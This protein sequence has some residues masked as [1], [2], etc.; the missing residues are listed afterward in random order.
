MPRKDAGC[1]LTLKEAAALFTDPVWA[2]TYP[3]L[4]NVKLAAD[5][6]KVPRNTIY[7][8]SSQGL[9]DDCKARAGKRL[10]LFRDR[11]IVTLSE[12]KLHGN[13]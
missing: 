12:G 4:L 1:R 10:V 13:G 6:L 11:L 8:W 2:A 7:A 5:L 3:P 9:L